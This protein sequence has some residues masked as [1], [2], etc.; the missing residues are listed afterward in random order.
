MHGTCDYLKNYIGD[1]PTLKDISFSLN[2]ISLDENGYNCEA[3]KR[4][5]MPS[6]YC[7]WIE[8]LN[9]VD[10]IHKKLGC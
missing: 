2:V 8:M 1:S 9:K 3:L 6:K 7:T 4:Y 5:S 10:A